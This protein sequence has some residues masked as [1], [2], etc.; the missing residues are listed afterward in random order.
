MKWMAR[1][2]IYR[3]LMKLAHRFDWHFAPLSGPLS[4]DGTYHRWC[5][6]CGF[7][8]AVIPEQAVPK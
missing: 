1:L 3:P 5:Q 6:W 7:R 8:A 2:R 4:P